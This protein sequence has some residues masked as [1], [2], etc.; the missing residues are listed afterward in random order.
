MFFLPLF[1]KKNRVFFQKKTRPKKTVFF[2][3]IL[4]QAGILIVFCY[5]LASDSNLISNGS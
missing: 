1:F 4:L 5:F 3:Q 2:L